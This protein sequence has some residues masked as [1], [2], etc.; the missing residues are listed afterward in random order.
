MVARPNLIEREDA[1]AALGACIVAGRYRPGDRLP[2]E[3]E[4]MVRLGLTRTKQFRRALEAPER[5]GTIRR[6]VG[7]GT[8]PAAEGPGR[9]AGLGRQV[10]PVRMMRARL[11]LEP[12]LGREAAAGACG[13]GARAGP[14]EPGPGRGGRHPGRVRGPRRP[15]PPHDRGGHGERPSAVALRPHQL[16]W[17]TGR[18]RRTRSYESNRALRQAIR[19]LPIELCRTGP[20]RRR[21]PAAFAAMR[22]RPSPVS[23][24][25]FGAV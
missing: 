10:T 15:A 18:W 5:G 1:R 11:A 14:D 6:H 23:A 12:A 25:L 22:D 20:N 24:R 7:E 19:A 9:L 4:R 3:R 8:F 17:C 13:R 21:D 16:R 2:P